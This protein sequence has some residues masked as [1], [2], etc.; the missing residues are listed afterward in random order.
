MPRRH[1]TAD[2]LQDPLSTERGFWSRG[3]LRIAGVDEAGRGPLAGP[4]VAAAVILPPDVRIDGADD[5]K[6]LT[7][8][9]RAA[10]FDEILARALCVSIAAASPRE[11]DRLNIRVATALAMQR[12]VRRLAIR[13]EHLLVDG[14]PVPEL[15]PDTHTALVGGDACVHCI[16]CASIV[17]KV[18]RDRLMTRLARHYPAYGWERNKGYGTRDHLDGLA[19]HGPTPHHRASFGPVGQLTLLGC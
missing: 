13:P 7:A 10:L 16:A 12:A 2:R 17:A 4:V 15:G 6:R 1:S 8:S 19:R 18:T 3:L 5:S 14:L 11:I 9:L